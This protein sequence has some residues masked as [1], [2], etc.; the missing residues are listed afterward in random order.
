MLGWND[1]FFTAHIVDTHAVGGTFLVQMP[2]APV[3]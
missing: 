2:M 1:D 3:A